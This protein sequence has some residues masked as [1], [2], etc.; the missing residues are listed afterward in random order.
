MAFQPVSRLAKLRNVS[1]AF[2][3]REVVCGTGVKLHQWHFQAVLTL[4]IAGKVIGMAC[5]GL[6]LLA[7][8]AGM[9]SS[10]HLR[11]DLLNVCMKLAPWSIASSNEVL[12]SVKPVVLRGQNLVSLESQSYFNKMVVDHGSR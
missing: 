6:L 5:I 8:A 1:Q 4:S 11:I 3:Q 12:T 9:Q 7:S 10:C 2:K